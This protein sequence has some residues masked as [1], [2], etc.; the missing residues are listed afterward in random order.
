MEE[1]ETTAGEL[2]PFQNGRR[3]LPPTRESVTHHFQVGQ[4]DGYITV[5]QYEDGAP[6]EMFVTLA[7]EGSTVRGLMDAVGVL[8]S[9]LLQY[10]VPLE[11]LSHKLKGV[12]FEPY[13]ITQ[14]KEIPFTSSP[15][16]YVFRWMEDRFVKGEQ[17]A[18]RTHGSNGGNRN[19]GSRT[20]T[21]GTSPSVGNTTSSSPILADNPHVAPLYPRDPSWERKRD[22][23]LR[24]RMGSS[25]T[26]CE[27]CGGVCVDEGG[28]PT[29][30]LCGWSKC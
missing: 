15:V 29:C 3:K 17:D 1:R 16:D 13:G 14:N 30:Y 23:I 10:G 11:T 12:T 27:D 7:K 2:S 8:T 25:G 19:R 26:L 5:G 28:C 22:E 18:E 21:G 6:G 20:S 9:Y 24:Q 4:M